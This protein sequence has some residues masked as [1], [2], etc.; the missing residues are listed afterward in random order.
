MGRKKKKNLENME[1]HPE[2]KGFDIKINEFGQ[3]VSSLSAEELNRFLNDKVEDKKFNNRESDQNQDP[4]A[5]P[6]E[7]P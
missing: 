2:L 4:N 3:I 5:K 7:N 1:T 6:H